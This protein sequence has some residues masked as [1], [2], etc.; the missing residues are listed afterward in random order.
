MGRL[1]EAWSPPVR[2]LAGPEKLDA[3]QR[4]AS[5]SIQAA[6]NV[7]RFLSL[8]RTSSVPHSAHPPPAVADER[9][10]LQ[11]LA[12]FGRGAGDLVAEPFVPFSCAVAP[13]RWGDGR[14]AVSC[15][16]ARPSALL[17]GGRRPQVRLGVAEH[18]RPFAAANPPQ[19]DSGIAGPQTNV[20]V[21]W[22]IEEAP[23]QR[24]DESAVAY[25]THAPLC[26]F[27]VVVQQQ[28]GPELL[29]PGAQV[30][31]RFRA[32][33]PPVRHRPAN[34]QRIFDAL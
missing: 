7:F 22:Q 17:T 18:N 25:E 34:G 8:M 21:H 10:Q 15:P 26:V 31:S 23:E 4:R 3:P 19:V 9:V 12:A 20:R 11:R 6:R 33:R 16:Q 5:C 30:Y 24:S 2:M 28:S 1:H 13:S 27:R 32:I 29:R 14:Q